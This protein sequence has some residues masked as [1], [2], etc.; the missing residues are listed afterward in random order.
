MGIDISSAFLSFNILI[1]CGSIEVDVKIP[2]IKPIILDDIIA[3]N[4]SCCL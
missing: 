3:K 2:A 4:I 1:N